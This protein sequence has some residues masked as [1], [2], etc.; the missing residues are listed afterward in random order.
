MDIDDQVAW[1]VQDQV[2]IQVSNN[3]LEQVSDCVW[4]QAQTPDQ[5]YN[6]GQDQ[7]LYQL[8]VDNEH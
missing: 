8:E 7:I 4:V 6:L 3:L 1:Q 2:E 5:A